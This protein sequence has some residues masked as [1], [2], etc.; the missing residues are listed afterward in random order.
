ML[1]FNIL[2]TSSNGNQ[3]T[4]LQ[5]ISPGN[6]DIQL[7]E[8][9]KSILLIS[10]YFCEEVLI[11]CYKK[12]LLHNSTISYNFTWLYVRMNQNP[13][14]ICTLGFNANKTVAIVCTKLKH[15]EFFHARGECLVQSHA[16][17]YGHK[18]IEED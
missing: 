6:G 8:F 14:H 9:C 2:C 10:R 4:R 17:V 13:T 15:L 1:T 11:A 3:T 7:L 16:E 5:R 18:G 12:L